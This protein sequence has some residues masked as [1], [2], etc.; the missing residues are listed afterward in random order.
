MRKEDFFEILGELDDDIVK[1][2][3]APV[4]K[5]G[6]WKVWGS[7]AACLALLCTAAAYQLVYRSG[8]P[9]DSSPIDM[10]IQ[11]PLIR[12][13][14]V[15]VSPGPD[16]DPAGYSPAS[17]FESKNGAITEALGTQEVAETDPMETETQGRAGQE[18][19][20][21]GGPGQEITVEDRPAQ[22]NPVGAGSVSPLDKVWG[23]S[24]TDENGCMVVWLTENTPENQRRVFEENPGLK[25][26]S[27]IFRTADFS[28]V[29]LTELLEDI[30]RA[31][32]NKELT[33]V[34]SAALREDIN[35]VE[36][37]MTT[38]DAEMAAHIKAFDTVGGAVIIQCGAGAAVDVTVEKK[39]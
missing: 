23:G 25:E 26:A 13:A 2:A 4:K 32:K 31:M 11:P 24:Y 8:L 35:R 36:V 27:T 3:A 22:E 17:G 30:S 21:Q 15:A 18:N 33:L 19:L 16:G 38:D 10:D 7:V 20:M 28:L 1:G 5:K 9:R 34:S 14:G 29:Y 37:T 12:D 6:N 39:L